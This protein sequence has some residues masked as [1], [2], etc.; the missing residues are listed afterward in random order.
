MRL[1]LIRLLLIALVYVLCFFVL[2]G[3]QH[4]SLLIAFIVTYILEPGI[5]EKLR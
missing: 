3:T 4:E 1:T 2:S 5:S